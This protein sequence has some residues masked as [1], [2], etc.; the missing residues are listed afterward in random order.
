MIRVAI[1]LLL[2]SALSVACTASQLR[3]NSG[4][5]TIDPIQTT[6]QPTRSKASASNYAAD[7]IRANRSVR[8]QLDRLIYFVEDP[9]A[10]SDGDI[11][12]AYLDQMEQIMLVL[13]LDGMEMLGEIERR[14][15]VPK[16]DEC[17]YGSAVAL[18]GM[19]NFF[20]PGSEGYNYA[21]DSAQAYY[22]AILRHYPE[23]SH[24]GHAAYPE[25]A[26]EIF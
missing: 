26:L 10:Y 2:V 16:G 25:D 9:W 1:G 24:A 11:T 7:C 22:E 14:G 12:N 18:D 15:A 13:K 3:G 5:R 17:L 19:K 20:P 4:P 21:A 23:S 6:D 8:Q